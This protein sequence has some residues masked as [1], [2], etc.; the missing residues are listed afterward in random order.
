MGLLIPLCLVIVRDYPAGWQAPAGED[1]GPAQEKGQGKDTAFIRQLHRDSRFW[2]LA[3]GMACNSFCCVGLYHIST[4]P[5][6]L[7]FPGSFAALMLSVHSIGA[8]ASKLIMGQLF[9]KKG[10]K[11]GILL[12]SA[13]AAAAYLLMVLASL[14]P[15]K[16][17]IVAAILC[18]GLSFGSQSLY[19]S[20]I[21]S[22]VFDIR[23]YSIVA[24]EI[25]VFT[26]MASAFSNP[27]VSGLYDITRSYTPAWILCSGMAVLALVCLMRLAGKQ[28]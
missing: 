9:D 8:I 22:R 23:Y 26:L 24:G 1:S 7:G 4:F 6:T 13:G 17:L 28:R 16:P 14:Q 2:L 20:A 12:G 11:G 18:Y 21:I 19:T 5:E 25:A 3:A 15:A 10:L 27:I